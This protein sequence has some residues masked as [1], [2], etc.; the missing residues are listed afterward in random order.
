MDKKT[1]DAKTLELGK[2]LSDIKKAGK[3][4]KEAKQILGRVSWDAYIQKKFGFS[5]RKA[6]YTILLYRR[7]HIE[8]RNA[9]QAKKSMTFDGEVFS[10][11]TCL[12]WI[13]VEEPKILQGK[14]DHEVPMTEAH[15]AAIFTHPLSK[16]EEPLRLVLKAGPIKTVF[17]FAQPV[18][19][20]ALIEASKSFYARPL[21]EEHKRICMK[22]SELTD[23]LGKDSWDEV[24]E[25][26]IYA[27]LHL[28]GF[29]RVSHLGMASRRSHVFR[30][31]YPRTGRPETVYHPVGV[32][33][34][35][36]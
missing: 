7:S 30:R 8:A 1:A 14:T 27:S 10:D 23:W 24:C 16:V 29:R 15:K 21:T 35:F 17:Q 13:A 9:K 32:L 19:A 31:V 28:Q 18:T 33:R 4:K 2:Q 12:S 20:G 3:W 36:I 26:I 34:F 6:D 22:Y 5:G 25:H 11:A